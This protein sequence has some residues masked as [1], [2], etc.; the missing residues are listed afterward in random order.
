MDRRCW[1]GLSAGLLIAAATP[2][3]GAGFSLDTL[4]PPPPGDGFFS[5]PDAA[6][7]P[8]ARPTVGV[9]VGGAD[10]PFG[11]YQGDALVADG[12]V[13]RDR[14]TAQAAVAVGIGPAVLDV[15]LPLVVAQDGAAPVSGAE[16]PPSGVLGDLRLGARF[17]ILER[18]A[19]AIALGAMAFLPI[20]DR[21]AWASD[22]AVRAQPQLTASGGGAL[23]RWSAVAGF[24]WR[25]TVVVGATTIG[26]AAVGGAAAVLRLA[27]GAFQ[28]G[29]EVTGR[30]P[31][32][33]TESLA[34]EGL[35]GARWR[36]GEL[37]LGLAAGGRLVGDSAGA[38]PLR[39]LV[40]LDW[41]PGRL[42]P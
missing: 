2:A 22:G 33:G 36:R 8:H 5:V 19:I 35:L 15:A 27:G 29:P 26:S 25:P 21:D 40:Q 39:G 32:E 4:E 20:G 16:R 30:L 14:I 10:R 7:G 12:W 6:S 23:V 38:A 37:A 31:V 17:A 1:R 28:V 41:T 11:L 18:P 3:M 9:A 13:V 42:D 24:H 34:I